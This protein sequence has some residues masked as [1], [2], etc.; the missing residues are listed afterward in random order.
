MDPARFSIGHS[1]M[2]YE[3]KTIQIR[4]GLSGSKSCNHWYAMLL[5]LKE[6][7]LGSGE[8]ERHHGWLT[9]KIFNTTI[10]EAMIGFI[11]FPEIYD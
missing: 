2:R 4:H 8:E 7:F 3:V 10:I 1:M 11:L 5:F 6:K 9:W